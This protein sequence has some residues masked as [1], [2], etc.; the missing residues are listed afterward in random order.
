DFESHADHGELR[1]QIDPRSVIAKL[2]A[3]GRRTASFSY[4]LGMNA[5]DH[6]RAGLG[7]GLEYTSHDYRSLDG[8]LL[9]NMQNYLTDAVIAPE[10]PEFIYVHVVGI[11]GTAH[12]FGIGAKATRN[13]L[14]WLDTRM[15]AVLRTLRA[16]EARG[17]RV[18]TLLTADHGM[19]DPA[20]YSDAAVLFKRPG[21]ITTNE[22]RYLGLHVKDPATLR[23]PLADA[24][25]LA[26][27]E[28]TVLREGEDLFLN[29]DNRQLQ[30]RYGPASCPE[31]SYSLAQVNGANVS[32]Y[33][34]PS[35]FDA[36]VPPYPYF[37]ANVATYLH[38][39]YHPDAL[40]I[41]KP[42]YSFMGVSKGMRGAHGGPTA[43]E[44]LVP[45]LTRNATVSGTRPMRTSDLLKILR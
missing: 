40:V 35:A 17:Y 45:L 20:A 21:I 16:G 4:V 15:G 13:Y 24:R 44:V 42:R 27:V 18:V 33:Q 39:K 23:R 6:M 38:A 19:V 31:E 28:L 25:D 12:R 32:P 41:A 36:L 9:S 34:C 43:D 3:E 37:V 30:F 7:E 5:D 14:R 1:R 11:D 26:S 29:S 10:W 8:R 2:Q 22:S